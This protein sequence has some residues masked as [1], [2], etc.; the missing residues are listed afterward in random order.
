MN[1][2]F[3]NIKNTIK[4]INFKSRK[5]LVFIGLFAVAVASGAILMS[6][7]YYSSIGTNNLVIGGYAFVSD[8]DMILKIYHE[9]R[10]ASGNGTGTYSRAYFIPE[11]NYNY[12][13]SMTY[14]TEGVTIDSF[15]N[16]EFSITTT[17][18][19]YCKVYFEAIDGY[20]LDATFRLY[21]EQTK[22]AEDYKQA[23]QIP[24]NDY[25]YVVNDTLTSC[26]DPDAVVE[27]VNRKI[28]VTTSR[29]LNC[30][31]YIDI[32]GTLTEPNLAFTDSSGTE[33]SGI[34]L[35]GGTVGVNIYFQ[36]E[37]D[38]EI[39]VTTDNENL[40]AT[41]NM[42][43]IAM[44]SSGMATYVAN[45]N[46][47]YESGSNN[48]VAIVSDEGAIAVLRSGYI[49]LQ[50]AAYPYTANITIE[51]LET[52][53]HKG[54]TIVMPVEVTCLDPNTLV[55]VWDRKK[56]K[57]VKRKI[58]TIKPGD[59]IYSYDA[60]SN[61]FITTKVKEVTINKAKELYH[62]H[63]D[64]EILTITGDHPVYIQNRG[65]ME[66]RELQDGFE[67][68]T[69]DGTYKCINKIEVELIEEGTDMYCLKLENNG[70]SFAVGKG[71]LVVLA[72]GVSVFASMQVV[73]V[74]AAGHVS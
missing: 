74:I 44:N 52:A 16:Y 20:V 3:L 38:G 47:Y 51:I 13:P 53:T 11:A 71:G 19:G 48:A 21:V 24:N 65:Y 68:L 10:D 34:S 63:F 6:Y 5:A 23:G 69:I 26:T 28:E 73:E 55:Y 39:I 64:D 22:D 4:N 15:E 41:V 61:T 60:N 62:L 9:D 36:T 30:D 37:S 14:C 45:K 7:G 17:K 66:V 67:L 32:N 31:I 27:I 18:P 50:S 56:Q 40:K 33:L 54:E 35:A 59:I 46:N 12:V 70:T 43:S 42:N 29:D 25:G 8:A 57:K 2:L 49:M 1:K 72:F 58:K